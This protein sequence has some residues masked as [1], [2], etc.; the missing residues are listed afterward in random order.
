MTCIEPH[1]VLRTKHL[2]KYVLTE[3]S[4]AFGQAQGQYEQ[5]LAF[6]A[7]RVEEAEAPACFGAKMLWRTSGA[8]MARDRCRHA[9]AGQGAGTG[10]SKGPVRPIHRRRARALDPR[11]NEPS[12]AATA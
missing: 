7:R 4:E 2:S 5:G 12:P 6:Y 1:Q 8:S 3:Q 10:L 9:A 11:R